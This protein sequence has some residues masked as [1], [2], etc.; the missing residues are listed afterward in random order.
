MTIVCM[1]GILHSLV[2]DLSMTE[3]SNLDI[4]R[5]V[6]QVADEISQVAYQVEDRESRLLALLS[7]QYVGWDSSGLGERLDQ[8]EEVITLA[9]EQGRFNQALMGHAWRI[10]YLVQAGKSTR[11]TMRTTLT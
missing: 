2:R 11:L 6:R 7:R 1:C 3:S 4:E 9:K 10:F 5:Q 8:L